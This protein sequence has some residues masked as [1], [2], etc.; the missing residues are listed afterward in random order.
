ML[1]TN[2]IA[3]LIIYS[4][5]SASMADTAQENIYLTQILNQIN[6]VKPLIIAA[7]HEQPKSNRIQ[8]HYSKYMD[9]SGNLHNGL[10]EDLIEIE[11][12]IRQKLEAIPEEPNHFKPINGDYFT[13]NAEKK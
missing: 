12:G 3:G 6:A 2:F 5:A 7:S 13:R 9:S 4:L 10:L 1:K 8:F 11:N